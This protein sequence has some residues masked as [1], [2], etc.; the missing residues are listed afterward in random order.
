MAKVW[1]QDG[2]CRPYDNVRFYNLHPH[3]I[4]DLASLAETLR[5]LLPLRYACV[6]RGATVNGE[7]MKQVRRLLHP[8]QKT[9][10]AP[11]LREV[12]RRWV[13]LDLDGIPL[14]EGTDP[15]DLVACAEA[16]RPRLP[17]AFRDAAAI[18][19]AT[20]SHGIKSGARLRWWAWLSRPVIGAELVQWFV[21]F[22]VDAATFRPVQ[23]IYT[24][25]PFFAGGREDPIPERLAMLPGAREVVQVPLPAMLR[26][27]KIA[28][29][30]VVSSSREFRG[31]GAAAL[32]YARR[33]LAAA[34]IG[35]RHETAKR[36]AAFL[37]HLARTGEVS[38]D[39]AVRAVADG[40]EAAGERRA[41]G[42]A[43]ARWALGHIGGGA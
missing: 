38:A 4:A 42:E 35:T 22:P 20:A 11:T 2:T 7:I 13:A 40:I 16:V 37:A 21:G 19:G 6:L 5:G 41:E 10:E 12:P 29:P 30:A 28:A 32:Q 3:P 26:P 31:G 23:P 14:P 9:G 8:D 43:L 18:I 1:R 36:M 39:D 34:P 15:R 17:H 33:T 27:V 25:R 24:A